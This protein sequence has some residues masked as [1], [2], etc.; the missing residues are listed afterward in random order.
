[1]RDSW[2]RYDYFY[3]LHKYTDSK[4]EDG[5]FNGKVKEIEKCDAF[6]PQILELNP[7]VIIVT[8]DHSTPAVMKSHSGHPVPFIISSDGIRTDNVTEFGER[9]C[10]RGLYG[11]GLTARS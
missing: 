9:S 6:L 4:G 10:A 8:G 2:Q 3:V 1:M 11:G 5:D 7:D